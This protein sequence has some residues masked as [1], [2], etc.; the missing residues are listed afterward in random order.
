MHFRQRR[1]GFWNPSLKKLV[2]CFWND[3]LTADSTSSSQLKRW[4]FKCS[5]SFGNRWKSLGVRSRLYGGCGSTEKF[6]RWIASL[7]AA[8]VWGLALSCWKNVS[9]SKNTN[10]V[11]H[12]L[13]RNSQ[14]NDSFFL[15]DATISADQFF[16]AILMKL[17]T[18]SHRSSTSCFVT[19]ICLPQFSIFEPPYAASYCIHI[20][21]LIAINGLHSSLNFNWGNFFRG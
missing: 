8:L 11:S 12:S 7:V 14:C 2:L 9:D 17:I 18:C 20:N 13:L 4:P 15:F 21:T 19:Q 6:R 10:N 5:F 3:F 1:T 16:N